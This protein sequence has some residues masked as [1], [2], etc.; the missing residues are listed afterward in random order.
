MLV[1]QASCIEYIILESDNLSTLFPNA[2]IN[3][4][5]F[6]LNSHLLFA[7]ATA[8]AVLPT[9]WL[10][11]LSILSYISGELAKIY[12]SKYI[13]EFTCLLL[14]FIVS[15]ILASLFLFQLPHTLYELV[16][17]RSSCYTNFLAKYSA[18]K[19]QYN[20]AQ[21]MLLTKIVFL[22]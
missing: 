15:I 12:Q 13:Y 17:F 14:T 22:V 18:L 5:G 20:V 11:D 1:L 3:F 6:Q 4:G 9:V 7:I 21:Q 16:I 8:L 19:L 10:R 2:H